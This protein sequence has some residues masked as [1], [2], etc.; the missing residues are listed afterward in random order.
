MA[1]IIK[2]IVVKATLESK[3][4]SRVV[5]EERILQLKMEVV[6]EIKEL[7]KKDSLRNTKR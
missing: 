1:I 6:R 2:E 5:E 7:L 4:N 3:G